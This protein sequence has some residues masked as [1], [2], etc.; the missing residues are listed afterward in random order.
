MASILGFLRKTF[1]SGTGIV[2]RVGRGARSTLKRGT[3]AI[4]LTRRRRR[5][6]RR[7]RRRGGRRNQ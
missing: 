5:G 1:K 7:A 4:G 3:N 2:R 6:S